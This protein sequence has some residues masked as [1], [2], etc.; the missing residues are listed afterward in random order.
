MDVLGYLTYALPVIGEMGDIVW[1][2]L[3]AFIFYWAFGGKIGLMGGVVNFIEEAVPGLDFIP[4]F[5]IAWLWQWRKE[6]TLTK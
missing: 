3:S 1:A 5:T 4:T 2:P 6:K